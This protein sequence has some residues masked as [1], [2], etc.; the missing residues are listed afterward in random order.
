M[1]Q[2]DSM[3]LNELKALKKQVEK[4][5]DSFETRR[6]KTALEAL[7]ATAKEQG[8]SLSELL[9]AASSTTKARG[10]AAAPKFANPH[11]PDETWS[12]RGRKPRWFI[13]AIE[14]GKTTDDLA[15]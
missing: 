15:I 6:K 11:N 8:F 7:E 1:D 13:E 2:L 3:D 5:I 9:D 10:Q 14:A 12:G 4:A